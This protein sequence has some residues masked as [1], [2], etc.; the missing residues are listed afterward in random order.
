M[1]ALGVRMEDPE[2]MLVARAVVS[3]HEIKLVPLAAAT[4]DRRDGIMPLLAAFCKDLCRLV[5]IG[6]PGGEDAIGKRDEPL[7]VVPDQA[8]DRHRP[9]EDR[10][11]DIGIARKGDPKLGARAL[12]RE[13]VPSALHMIVREDRAADDR[14]IGV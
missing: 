7:F 10:R 12:H 11:L 13:D 9:I 2:R 14:K 1:V 6:A 5:A 8:N 3:K 4:G